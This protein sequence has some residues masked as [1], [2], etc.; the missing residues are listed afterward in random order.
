MLS[1][2][3]QPG[4][5][6]ASAQQRLCPSLTWERG[7]PTGPKPWLAALPDLEGTGL[8][9]KACITFLAHSSL[10]GT[11]EEALC[12]PGQVSSARAQPEACT[13]HESM[14]ADSLLSHTKSLKPPWPCFGLALTHQLAGGHGEYHL[15]GFPSL[16]VSLPHGPIIL[17]WGAV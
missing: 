13:P 5:R 14:S 16:A 17:P 10:Q 9:L 12:L 2:P 15:S 7:Y 8:L 3:S 4:E 6:D 1:I 11:S